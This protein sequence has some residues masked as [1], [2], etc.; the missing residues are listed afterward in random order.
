MLKQSYYHEIIHVKYL[1]SGKRVEKYI[2]K[3]RNVITWTTQKTESKSNHLC[4]LTLSHS[5]RPE[6][7]LR[8]MLQCL[9]QPLAGWPITKTGSGMRV[10]FQHR[11]YSFQHNFI[12]FLMGFVPK[13]NSSW[14]IIL[15]TSLN[16]YNPSYFE[17]SKTLNKVDSILHH[18][19]IVFTSV[20]FCS[21]SMA[22]KIGT[23]KFSL[24]LTDDINRLKT[25][26]GSTDFNLLSLN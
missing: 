10:G 2:E 15:I 12:R 20:T 1:H 24:K 13:T 18:F 16:Q 14:F 22:N 7:G 26:H 3:I 11:S 17:Q 6:S 8:E 4:A 5:L 19:I 23:C 25:I 21:L 9:L